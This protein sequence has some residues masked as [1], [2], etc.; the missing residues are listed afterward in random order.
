MHF[1]EWD[2]NGQRITNNTFKYTLSYAA[3]S[4]SSWMLTVLDINL[5]DDGLYTCIATNI[6]GIANASAMLEV[7]GI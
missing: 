5:Q 3:N 7:Q 4:N 1:I 2:F 6:H